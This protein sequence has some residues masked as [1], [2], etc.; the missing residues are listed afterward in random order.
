LNW[1]ITGTTTLTGAVVINTTNA[2]SYTSSLSGAGITGYA[3][4]ST[5]TST[6]NSQTHTGYD[7]VVTPVTGGFTGQTYNFFRLRNTTVAS[8]DYYTIGTSQIWNGTQIYDFKFGT[9]TSVV[10]NSAG[11][12]SL[13]GG[14]SATT[15]ML[16]FE[17][18]TASS[19]NNNITFNFTGGTHDIIAGAL[20]RTWTEVLIDTATTAG[21][22]N[23][24]NSSVLRIVPSYS[25]GNCTLNITGIDYNPSITGSGTITHHAVRIR[26]GLSAFGHTNSPTA[27]MDIGASVTASSALRI[28][29]GT[30]PSSPNDGDIWYDGT[31]IKIRVGGTTKTFTIL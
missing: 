12:M 14:T 22:G 4:L 15:S 20:T 16:L 28:R 11:A 18:T 7:F 1:K 3:F 6:A 24:I 31:D 10:R 29:S 27:F 26:S 9:A 17:P 21:N 13:R 30:A 2:L 19:T 25:V 8:G 5:L 23:T